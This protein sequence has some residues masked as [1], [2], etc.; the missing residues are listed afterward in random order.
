MKSTDED[1]ALR[2]NTAV[3]RLGRRIRRIDDAQSIGRA[4]LSALS[5]LV[6]GGP[7]AL[8]ELATEEMV[9]AATM[10]HVVKGLIKDGLA[11]KSADRADGRRAM[12]SATRKGTR[13]MEDARAARL[14]FYL[15]CLETL[16]ADDRAAVARF[17]TLAMTWIDS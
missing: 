17:A 13:F 10:H 5:V 3:T 1:V 6:F 9:S 14:A 7:C 8:T 11:A 4:R 16:S 2:L 12:I 15:S